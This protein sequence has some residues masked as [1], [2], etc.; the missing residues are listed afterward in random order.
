[1]IKLRQEKQE[2]RQW[3]KDRDFRDQLSRALVAEQGRRSRETQWY[4]PLVAREM[5]IQEGKRYT[6]EGRRAK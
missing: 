1:M 5:K 2:R 6:F 4:L 3:R